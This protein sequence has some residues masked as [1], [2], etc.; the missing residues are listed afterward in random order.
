[1]WLMQRILLCFSLTFALSSYH[2]LGAPSEPG[3]LHCGKQSFQ[4]ITNHLHQD[5]KMPVFI[6]WDHQGLPHRLNNS[7]C[8][9]WVTEDPGGSVILEAN[10]SGCYV[11]EWG[12]HYVLLIGVEEADA[13][14]HT[15]LMKKRLLKCP[16]NLP[17]QDAPGADLCSSMPVEDRLPCM[18][19]PASQGDC[20]GL[21]CCFS[22]VGE[23]ASCYY[24]NTVTSH[25]TQDGHFSIAVSRDAASPPLHLESVRLV[26]GNDSGCEPVMVTRTFVLFRFP[27]TSCGTT[28]WVTGDQTV[29]ENE[30]I[31]KRDVRTGD[32]GSITRDNIFRLQ[33][34]CSYSL[35]SNTVP[36]H[37]QVLTLSPPLP[38][39]QPGPLALE[40]QIAKDENYGSYY[41]AA[42]YP[43]VK[44]LRD[45]VYVDVSILHRTDPNL[46]L[47]LQQCWATTS[48]SPL[49]Q[50]QW[51]ILVEGCP[52]TGDNYQTQRIAV[53]R[54]LPFPSY[55]QRF[56]FST[57]GF[58]DSSR[59][60]QA[61]SGQVFLHCSA[62]VCQPAGML[63][64][65]VTC[66]PA[67][68][69]RKSGLYF[70]NSTASISSKGPMIL[71]QDTE[72]PS[73]KTHKTTGGPV[74]PQAL[75]VA[76]FAGTFIIG[77]LLVS[78]LAIRRQK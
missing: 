75:W 32:H 55:H 54:S 76:G 44:F 57:F 31:A 39:T 23:A 74:D 18:P 14:G 56:S 49:H 37:V 21:G 78:Y 77:V 52:Y 5:G 40:L 71:L 69:K 64:C 66:P 43:V 35:N 59:A 70:Q 2:T 28:S 46:G 22:P 33:V 68:R 51:P 7:E 34:S 29:Y 48:P 13:A 50:P 61:L 10:Y 9:M 4:F 3:V 72:D 30:L 63:S 26:F 45:P 58:V 11:K 67:N 53:E 24:G 6:V 15:V 62:S 41:A 25:C 65:T 8:G 38:K 17:A 73:E 19:S 27:F 20:E 12:F 60:K 36:V 1:M 47:L 42:D 16:A